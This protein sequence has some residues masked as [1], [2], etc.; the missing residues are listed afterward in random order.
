[1]Q[2]GSRTG[3][4]TPHGSLYAVRGRAD[5]QGLTGAWVPA[6]RLPVPAARRSIHTPA[7]AVRLPPAGI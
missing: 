7:G 5:A 3:E 4:R 1:M 6:E 2:K